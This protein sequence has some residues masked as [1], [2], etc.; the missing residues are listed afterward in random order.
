[1]TAVPVRD[2]GFALQNVSVRSDASSLAT[3]R[4]EAHLG[5]REIE[6]LRADLDMIAPPEAAELAE[7]LVALYQ[8]QISSGDH[9]R[10]PQLTS[11]DGP[12]VRAAISRVLAVDTREAG[13]A[14]EDVIKEERMRRV[15]RALEGAVA[16]IQR[17]ANMSARY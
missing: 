7:P 3:R 2:F 10:L 6:V 5:I 15:L 13:G 4:A 8:G 9:L 16:N 11:H 14:Q 17:Q 12:A 1:M